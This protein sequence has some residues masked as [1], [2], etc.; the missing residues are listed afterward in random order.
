MEGKNISVYEK[1]LRIG[2]FTETINIG[3]VSFFGYTLNEVH[4]VARDGANNN[5]GDY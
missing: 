2:R 1:H 3:L 4:R 5:F